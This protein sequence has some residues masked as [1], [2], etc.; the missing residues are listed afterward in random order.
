[1][2]TLSGLGK[3]ESDSME[4]PRVGAGRGMSARAEGRQL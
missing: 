2:A 4:E 1:M 3:D